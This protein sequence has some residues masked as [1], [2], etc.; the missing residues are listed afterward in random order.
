MSAFLDVF[1][2]NLAVDQHHVA[3]GVVPAQLAFGAQQETVVAHPV[4]NVVRQ[5]GAAF[6]AVVVGTG[7]PHGEREL[8]LPVDALGAV[9]DTSRVRYAK[10]GMVA[11]LTPGKL[12]G[13][14]V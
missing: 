3:L 7:R 9:G 1:P 11:M 2:N 10:A 4:R 6:G 8:F 5:P 12:V 14:D 13:A